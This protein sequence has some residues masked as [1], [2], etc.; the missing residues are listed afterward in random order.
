VL[1]DGPS[2]LGGDAST[3][4]TKARPEPEQNS[5]YGPGGSARHQD[6]GAGASGLCGLLC[7]RD[8][9]TALQD[10]YKEQKGEAK[11][12]TQESSRKAKVRPA[13]A[14]GLLCKR[15]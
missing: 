10:A 2:R 6:E 14:H 13:F 5:E 11:A 8:Y 15:D 12:Q 3:E 7:K 4:A 9:F 1:R